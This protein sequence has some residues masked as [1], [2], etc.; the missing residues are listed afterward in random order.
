[1]LAYGRSQR[2]LRFSHQDELTLDPLAEIQEQLPIGPSE[3]GKLVGVNLE[4]PAG[5]DNETTPC[6]MEAKGTKTT[7]RHNLAATPNPSQLFEA[8]L[9]GNTRGIA[10]GMES[11]GDRGG[12]GI[13]GGEPV[14]A[15]K[16]FRLEMDLGSDSD[17]STEQDVLPRRGRCG[18]DPVQSNRSA[19]KLRHQVSPATGQRQHQ[20]RGGMT[21]R[22]RQIAQGHDDD[23]DTAFRSSDFRTGENGGAKGRWQRED[24]RDAGRGWGRGGPYL[25]DARKMICSQPKFVTPDHAEPMQ[26]PRLSVPPPISNTRPHIAVQ[27]PYKPSAQVTPDSHYQTRWGTAEPARSSGSRSSRSFS[28]GGASAAR[29]AGASA[30]EAGGGDGYGSLHGAGMDRSSALRKM[31]SLVGVKDVYPPELSRIWP[32]QNFNAIQSA[33]FQTAAESDKNVVVSAPTG[34]GKALCQQ[35][36]D[37]WT[38]KFSPLGI[39]LA[40]LTSDST[41]G[42]SKG[43]VSLRDLASADVIL[44]TPEKWDSITRRWKE[45]AFLV[46]TVLQNIEYE[47]E[48]INILHGYIGSCACTYC[49]NDVVSMGLPASRMRFIALSAT[50]PNAD[51]F[52][53][54]LG[55]EVFRFGDEFRPVPLQVVMQ[56]LAT[57][58]NTAEDPQLAK[59]MIRGVA[60]HNSGLSPRDRGLVERAFLSGRLYGWLG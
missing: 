2:T 19:P 6:S 42:P 46:C 56:Y 3:S 33:L 51:D 43:S 26:P 7:T 18:H 30:Q 32:F 55:A 12:G 27:N 14:M 29:S 39:R 31:P 45:H 36:L 22:Y 44:T 25:D 58:A 53:S 1:M 13:Y 35:T 16:R 34:C 11:T 60:I 37:D 28:P 23:S 38:A 49:V 47:I 20:Q 21:N 50:L 41:S 10:T 48:F 59:L 5:G 54:F 40:E 15:R 24:G 52:G 4:L 9:G 8:D 57:A 17:S